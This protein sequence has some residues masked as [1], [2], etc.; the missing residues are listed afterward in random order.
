ML[1]YMDKS[2]FSHVTTLHSIVGDL[3][4]FQRCVNTIQ[5]QFPLTSAIFLFASKMLHLDLLDK[6]SV[7]VETVRIVLISY[8]VCVIYSPELTNIGV[9]SSNTFIISENETSYR[10]SC[11]TKSCV[12]F[13]CYRLCNSLHCSTVTQ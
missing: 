11:F 8:V 3:I 5:Q 10:E 9:F 12:H 1:I 13:L 2:G 7:S 4:T 6:Q